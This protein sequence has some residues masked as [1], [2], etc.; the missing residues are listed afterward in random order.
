MKKILLITGPAGDAQGWGD[1]NVTKKIKEA[2]DDS[3]KSAQIAFVNTMDDFFLALEKNSF[4]IVWSAL[5]HISSNSEIIGM[6]EGDENGLQTFLMI[7][8]FPISGL[9]QKP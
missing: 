2:I 7:K 1:L 9:M 5:Y 3:G 4:D 6:G 8:A